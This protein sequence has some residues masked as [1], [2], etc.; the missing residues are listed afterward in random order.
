MFKNDRSI[1]KGKLKSSTEEADSRPFQHLIE[2][3]KSKNQEVVVTSND[4]DVAVYCWTYK[5][6]YRFYECKEVW[7]CSGAGEKA[8]DIHIHVLTKK[9]GDH[10]S[11]LIILKTYVLTWCDVTR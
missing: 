4:T 5:N 6:R 3:T 7:V 1:T 8:R 10:L 11:S 2:A 9:L